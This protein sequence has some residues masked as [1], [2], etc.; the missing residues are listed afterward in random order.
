MVEEDHSNPTMLHAHDATVEFFLPQPLFQ[1][2][3]IAIAA[4]AVVVSFVYLSIFYTLKRYYSIRH[5]AAAKQQCIKA[6]YQ[7]TNLLAN[8]GFALYGAYVCLIKQHSDNV[9]F[10]KIFDNSDALEHIL[11]YEQYYIFGAMQVGYNLWSLPVGILYVNESLSMIAHHVAVLVICTLTATS[12]FGFRLHAPFLLG[13]FEISSVPL[14]IMNYLKDHKEWSEKHA[15]GIVQ[16]TRVIFAILFLLVRILLG[17]PH[18]VHCIRGSYVAMTG[19]GDMEWY[20][21]G[22]IGLVWGGE[23]M[24]L[25]L[26]MYWA[27]L[28]VKGI[29]KA[30]MSKKRAVLSVK[31]EKSI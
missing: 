2:A 4:F 3:L 23:I 16:V 14:S 7:L 8:L 9:L 10:A 29:G 6:S 25:V 28:I 26:Q 20:L 1:Q 19:E 31:K 27:W 11:G 5:T 12:H 21:R 22:W 17:T 30:L 13:I 18:A 24:L 15:K